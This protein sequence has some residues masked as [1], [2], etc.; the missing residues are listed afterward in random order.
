[1]EIECDSQEASQ[2]QETA[3]ETSDT[4]LA[5][6]SAGLPKCFVSFMELLHGVYAGEYDEEMTTLAGTKSPKDTL[7][8]DEALG[9]VSPTLQTK[10]RETL[11]HVALVANKFTTCDQDQAVVSV[12]SLKRIASSPNEEEVAAAD[13]ERAQMWEKARDQRKKGGQRSGRSDA[14]MHVRS[15][16]L[17]VGDE[18]QS[19]AN[20]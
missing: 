15:R 17:G 12:R 6:V 13:K 14:W 2:Q 16:D 10:L 19:S 3:W 5:Q 7:Q 8:D 4:D 18:V 11:R 9:G 1:M 20:V